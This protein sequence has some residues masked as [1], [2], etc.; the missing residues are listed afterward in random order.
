MWFFEGLEA[1]GK[2][3]PDTQGT[4]AKGKSVGIDREA[5]G[6]ESKDTQRQ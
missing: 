3:K 1:G 6:R 5:C 2:W 4:N